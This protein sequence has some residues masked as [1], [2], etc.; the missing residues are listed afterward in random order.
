VTGRRMQTIAVACL[1]LLAAVDF[2][3]RIYVPRNFEARG[4]GSF[5]PTAVPPSVP[6]NEIRRDLAAWLP[7][8]RPIAAASGAAA[9]T[10]W[11]LVLLAVFFDRNTTFAVVRATSAAG[12][13][14]KV[15]RVVEGDQLYGFRVS[16]IEPLRVS[17]TGER[18]ERELQLFKPAGAP[19]V[20]AG[21]VATGPG[22][23]A[24]VAAA[25]PNASAAQ[26]A[27]QAPPGPVSSAAPQVVSGNEPKP[28]DAFKV[29]DSMRGL[30]VM[31]A[32]V[33]PKKP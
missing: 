28:G 14:S 8:L 4:A 3:Q 31:D 6:A 30:K 17:L 15:Q 26:T 22:Q 33:P 10:D 20:G 16:R 1:A 9:D 27:K 23:H 24:P 32:P 2:W 21:P 29:P 7:K 19:V 5:V 13:A 18:G 25:L 11:T 12:G